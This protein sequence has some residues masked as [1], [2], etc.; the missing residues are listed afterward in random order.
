MMIQS[1]DPLNQVVGRQLVAL[2]ALE[3]NDPQVAYDYASQTYEEN[4]EDIYAMTIVMHKL[5]QA[6]TRQ[7]AR[8]LAHRICKMEPDDKH[9][10]HQMAKQALSETETK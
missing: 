9:P 2:Y 1:G 4:P 8:E 5:A 7:K 6:G 3:I 10:C